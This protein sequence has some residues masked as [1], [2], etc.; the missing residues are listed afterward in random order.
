MSDSDVGRLDPDVLERGHVVVEQAGAMVSVWLDRPEVRNAQTPAMWEALAH[1]GDWV[2]RRRETVSIAVIRGRGSSFSA[3]LDRRMFTPKGI[4]GE[5]SLAELTTRDDAGLDQAIAE[6]Q[7][8]FTWQREVPALTVAA[9]SGHAI[10]A[11]FQLALA[12]DVILAAEDATFAMR[13]TSLGLVPDLAGTAPL[14]RAVGPSRAIDICATGRS[15]TAVEAERWGLVASVAN[16]LDL[17]VEA[18]AQTI[19]AAPP[20][21]V[22]DLLS[23]LRDAPDRSTVEQRA[24]ERQAQIRRL[25]TITGTGS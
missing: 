4:P 19:L 3:G 23:L 2:G 20:G 10:G 18:Y 8:A 1:V 9:V 24:A 15:V 25:R 7:R 21:S 16:D 13:E 5:G 17:A 22:S 6:F 14:V 12:C 11:G